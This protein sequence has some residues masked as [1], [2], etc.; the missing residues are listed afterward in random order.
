M[1]PEQIKA[2]ALVAEAIDRSG[3]AVATLG[4]EPGMKAQAPALR[5][6]VPLTMKDMGMGDMS[7][8]GGM[9]MPGAQGMQMQGQM[10][11]MQMMMM[12]G[13][14]SGQGFPQ[15]WGSTFVEI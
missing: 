12:M 7:A 4:P 14:M 2:Y 5:E 10:N 11:P 13:Q 1:T 15:Q 3:M 8:M 6:P 9:Q